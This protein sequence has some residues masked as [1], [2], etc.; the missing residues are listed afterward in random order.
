MN[1]ARHDFDGRQRDNGAFIFQPFS[2]LPG[3][4]RSPVPRL[5]CLV[6]SCRLGE[7]STGRRL[8]VLLAKPSRAHAAMRCRDVLASTEQPCPG[9]QRRLWESG[10]SETPRQR[11]KCSDCSSSVSVLLPQLPH[12]QR[13]PPANPVQRETLQ[14]HEGELGAEITLISLR[15]RQTNLPKRFYKRPAVHKPVPPFPGRLRWAPR[16][17]SCTQAEAPG[18]NCE[19]AAQ[20]P[21]GSRS[22]VKRRFDTFTSA[23]PSHLFRRATD[24]ATVSAHA[25]APH[26][27]G[28]TRFSAEIKS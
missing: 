2:H 3:A 23:V 26:A 1:Y 22:R 12:G 7:R 17:G 21:G 11:E 25:A 8:L 27:P 13:L 14:R 24:Q 10:G 6:P 19:R 15:K 4:S 18:S 28:L 16:P 20:R 5:C 9:S